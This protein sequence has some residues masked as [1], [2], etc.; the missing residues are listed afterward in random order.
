M[1]FACVKAS[2]VHTYSCVHRVFSAYTSVD[3]NVVK[4]AVNDII[5]RGVGFAA[6]QYPIGTSLTLSCVWPPRGSCRGSSLPQTQRASVTLDGITQSPSPSCVTV[7][8]W[9]TREEWY[10]SS[11]SYVVKS[12]SASMVCSFDGCTTSNLH[13]TISSG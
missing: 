3:G 8:K 1:R 13:L 4:V 12:G 6:V 7:V 2:V 5:M 9:A 10:N 11:I